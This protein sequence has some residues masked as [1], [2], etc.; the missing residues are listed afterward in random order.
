MCGSRDRDRQADSI[1][2]LRESDLDEADRI[3]RI[4]FGNREG[5]PENPLNSW[6]MQITFSP[7]GRRARPRHSRSK[8]T[9]GSPVPTSQRAGAP[10]DSSGRYRWTPRCGIADSP[11]ALMAPVVES[12]DAWGVHA[13]R[14][15]H[16]GR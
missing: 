11:N 12:L 15:V 6:A 5:V 4:A 7:G 2:R 8:W 3:M 10:S 16:P 1:R 13:C 9:A 14:P